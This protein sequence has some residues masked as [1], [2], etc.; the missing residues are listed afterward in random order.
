MTEEPYS[1]WTTIEVHINN[2][3]RALQWC[4]DN[5]G[6]VRS[7]PEIWIW[8]NNVYGNIHTFKFKHSEDAVALS[9]ITKGSKNEQRRT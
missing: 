5:L 2:L 7:G 9:L 1:D 3:A 4:I 6:T 8:Y